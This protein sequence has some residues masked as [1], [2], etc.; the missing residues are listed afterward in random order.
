M[1]FSKGSCDQGIHETVKQSLFPDEHHL[2]LLTD[3]YELTMA[4]PAGERAKETL[5]SRH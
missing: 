2:G 1:T 4:A 5:T 3:L